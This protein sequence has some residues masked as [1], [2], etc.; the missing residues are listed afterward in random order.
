[1]KKAHPDHAL[2]MDDCNLC[3]KQ[4]DEEYNM[5]MERTGK[6]ILTH[7]LATASTDRDESLRPAPSTSLDT[8][9]PRLDIAST[10]NASMIT[11]PVNNE[12][13]QT[14]A[15]LESPP[16][17]ISTTSFGLSDPQILAS[18]ENTP[19]KGRKRM[20]KDAYDDAPPIKQINFG[21]TVQNSHKLRSTP[22]SS[23][24]NLN[25]QRVTCSM[26]SKKN[27]L[28]PR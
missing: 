27:Q 14:A 2:T 1:M 6:K 18:V 20:N 9:S 26:R 21:S 4:T 19:K 11:C 23:Q 17:P 22:E 3:W 8:S 13:I 5:V 24:L 15:M 25:I 12:K 16:S 7:L 28:P 10:R